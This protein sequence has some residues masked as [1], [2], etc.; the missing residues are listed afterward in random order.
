[1]T[2]DPRIFIIAGIVAVSGII[3]YKLGTISAYKAEAAEKQR[4]L[5]DYKQL[6][7]ARD[8][9]A[10]MYNQLDAKATKELQDAQELTNSLRDTN[11]RLRI[12]AVC[13]ER[14]APSNSSTSVDN[15][16]TA[17]LDPVARQAYFSLRDGINRVQAQLSAC[18]QVVISF[19]SSK[20]IQ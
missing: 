12:S 13:T 9:L 7:E 18:Q 1:M 17:E 14:A 8:I 10:N 15:G 20:E 4:L 2:I 19:Q 16:N 5:T 11:K 3:G 6:V